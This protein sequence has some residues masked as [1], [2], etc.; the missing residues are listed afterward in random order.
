MACAAE[1]ASFNFFAV[2]AA[3][4]VVQHREGRPVGVASISMGAAAACLPSLPDILEPAVHPNHRRF[5]HSITTATALACLMHR[6]YKWEA[7]DEWKRLA[8]VLLLVGGGA[9]L[10]HLARDALTAKSLPLI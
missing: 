5:F 7:E 1:H 8:R 4:A 9:Y 6:V 2:A 10:A 3:T